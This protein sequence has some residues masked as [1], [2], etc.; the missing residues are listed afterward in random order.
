LFYILERN[1]EKKVFI[2]GFYS[3][4]S[5]MSRD[6]LKFFQSY[7]RELADI[8][9]DNL[10]RTVSTKLGIKLGKLFKDRDPSSNLSVNLRK[11]YR[12]LNA[13]PKIEKLDDNTY[14]VQ[15][16]H[17]K[18]FCPIGGN[19][20]PGNANFV[21]HSI[22]IPYTLGFLHELEPDLKFEADIKNCIIST[23]TKT[24]HYTLHVS[25]NDL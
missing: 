7:I 5:C 9:G 4:Q 3:L 1:S 6:S 11:I 23:H 17:Q 16:K 15:V 10:P 19:Y 2:N 20:K 24:C 13:K 22:C 25:P 12:A 18:R 21:H 8:G 14:D